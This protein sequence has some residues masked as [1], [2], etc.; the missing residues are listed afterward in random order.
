MAAALF[1]VEVLLVVLVLE[2]VTLFAVE[3][4]FV[5]LVVFCFEVLVVVFVF[6]LLFVV[7]ITYY[8]NL[9]TPFYIS[10][11]KFLKQKSRFYE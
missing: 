7:N 5:V 8:V 1:A 9:D 4:V 2:E 6:V 10:I 3:G 11:L